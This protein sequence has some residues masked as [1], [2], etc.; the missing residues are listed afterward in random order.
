MNWCRKKSLIQV[1]ESLLDVLSLPAEGLFIR[2][3]TWCLSC[4]V[5][6][7]SLLQIDFKYVRDPGLF[8]PVLKPSPA[9]AKLPNWLPLKVSPNFRLPGKA[10]HAPVVPAFLRLGTRPRW[11]RS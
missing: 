10:F 7:D 11:S 9:P 1:T 8:C 4:A 5:L 3:V 2:L 6:N